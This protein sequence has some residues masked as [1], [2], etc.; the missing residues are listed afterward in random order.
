MLYV[1]R[2]RARAPYAGCII[3]H[4]SLITSLLS[5]F[6]LSRLGA[7]V[8][9]SYVLKCPNL[10]A[11]EPHDSGSRKLLRCKKRSVGGAGIE[12]NELSLRV[13]CGE[14]TTASILSAKFL[15][16]SFISCSRGTSSSFLYVD[17]LLPTTSC[18]SNSLR[19]IADLTRLSFHLIEPYI[20]YATKFA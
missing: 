1:S 19:Q 7:E 12:L 11:P 5:R 15:G 6:A 17:F 20:I 10:G 8:Y 16:F 2:A 18:D 13:V 4:I 3:L 14:P 9:G